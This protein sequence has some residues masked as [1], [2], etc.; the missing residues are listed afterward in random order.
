MKRIGLTGMPGSG[1]GVFV[2]IAKKKGWKIVRMGDTV[3]GFVRKKGLKINDENVGK[4]ADLER[5]KFGY[6]IWA[7][8][9]LPFIKNEKTVIDG[10]RSI[11]EVNVFKKHF[12]DFIV[13]GVH[14]SPETRYSRIMKRKRVDDVFSKEKFDERDKRELSWGI[15]NVIA[16]SDVMIVN[17]GSVEEFKRNIEK[18]LEE[19]VR[20]IVL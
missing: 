11:E 10:I 1:K 7:E 15:G 9:S 13:V 6:G 19:I 2:E 12:P 4:N 16:L 17:E 3:W 5:K 20:H 18:V 14:S 8:R